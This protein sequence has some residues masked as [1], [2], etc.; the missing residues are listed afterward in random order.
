MGYM[1][2]VY[3]PFSMKGNEADFSGSTSSDLL[4]N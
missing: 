3:P 2:D 1:T 4:D